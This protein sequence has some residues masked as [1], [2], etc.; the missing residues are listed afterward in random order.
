MEV[1]KE[2]AVLAVQPLVDKDK[3][4]ISF[5]EREGRVFV[6][7]RWIVA[8]ITSNQDLRTSWFGLYKNA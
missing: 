7:E 4:K 8:K 1:L 3:Q 5:L 2:M 6:L